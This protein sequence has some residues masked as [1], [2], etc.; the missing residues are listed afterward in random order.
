MAKQPRKNSIPLIIEP[1]PHDYVGLPFLTLVQ[2]KKQPMLAVIDNIVDGVINAYVLDL[3]GP[4]NVNEEIVIL[5]AAEWYNENRSNYPISIEFSKRGMTV[6]M[7]K[8][9]RSLNAEFVSRIIGPVPKF[10][11]SGHNTIKKRRKRPLPSGVVAT[12]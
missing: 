1:H 7:S 4:E 10:A 6:D 3:C 12:L 2:F 8:I 5:T 11:M 9:Y